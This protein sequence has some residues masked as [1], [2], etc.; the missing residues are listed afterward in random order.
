MDWAFRNAGVGE[1]SCGN[2]SLE[3]NRMIAMS[4]GVGTIWQVG[5]PNSTDQH[6]ALTFL[7]KINRASAEVASE[8]YARPCWPRNWPTDFL[9]EDSFTTPWCALNFAPRLDR[10]MLVCRCGRRIRFIWNAGSDQKSRA[11]SG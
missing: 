11:V 7:E 8:H 3:L 2:F 6:D 1:R 10:W 5:E 4:F 9:S